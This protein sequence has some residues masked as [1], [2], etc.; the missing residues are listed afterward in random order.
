MALAAINYLTN[1]L[2]QVNIQMALIPS[3][4]LLAKHCQEQRVGQ[5]QDFKLKLVALA[6]EIGDYFNEMDTLSEEELEFINPIFSL[7][8]QD[9]EG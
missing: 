3:Q 9:E 1:T 2:D 5:H 7:L 4:G 8:N 6:N